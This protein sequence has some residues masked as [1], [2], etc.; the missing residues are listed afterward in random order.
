MKK[1]YLLFI[2]LILLCQVDAIY[3]QGARGGRGNNTE[4]KSK[5][6]NNPKGK[7][8]N[9]PKSPAQQIPTVKIKENKKLNPSIP[10][11]VKILYANLNISVNEPESE[12][13]IADLDGNIFE[14]AESYTTDENGSPLEYNQFPV[15]TYTLTVRKYGF[16]TES[17]TITVKGDKMNRF[18][19]TLRPTMAFLSVSTNIDGTSIEIENVG[20][21]E[22]QI[23]DYALEPGTYRLKISKSGYESQ[24]REV[25][26]NNVGE[27]ENLAIV[28]LES[29]AAAVGKGEKRRIAV[30]MQSGGQLLP[31]DLIVSRNSIEFEGKSSGLN[32][33]VTR[34]NAVD[35]IESKDSAGS[36]IE[37]K[38]HGFFGG[39]FDPRKRPVRLYPN[40]PDAK[41]A[42][43]L[44]ESWRR[45]DF[46]ARQ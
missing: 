44:M 46:S 9:P 37:F 30:R 17:R 23:D 13:F 15:G 20:E 19:V 16:D 34:G 42:F 22:N 39:K 1:T 41:A 14:D 8:K 5:E 7:E 31:G 43:Q 38:A 3:S 32:F 2:C 27:R 45:G 25:V 10:K 18:P 4:I 6:T 36:Y 40:P 12:I 35:F 24:M 21:F 11:P 26:L 28:L 29:P 33:I